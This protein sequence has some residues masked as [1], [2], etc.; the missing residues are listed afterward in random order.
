MNQDFRLEF[1]QTLTVVI[2]GW[3]PL[4]FKSNSFLFKDNIVT[5][6]YIMM[7]TT[8]IGAYDSLPEAIADELA[9]IK[10]S[11]GEICHA[12][13]EEAVVL[14]IAEQII[15]RQK[16]DLAHRASYMKGIL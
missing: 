7:G 15:L 9:R 10:H 16:R 8:Y 14:A 4:C 12:Y 6:V 13:A 1:G 5:T 2:P 11:H 3:A